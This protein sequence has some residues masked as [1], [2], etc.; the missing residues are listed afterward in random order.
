MAESHDENILCHV[1]APLVMLWAHA[2]KNQTLAKK[3]HI[4]SS[5]SVHNQKELWKCF[6]TNLRTSITLKFKKNTRK[7]QTG[8]SSPLPW[9]PLR[10]FNFVHFTWHQNKHLA[11]IFENSRLFTLYIKAKIKDFFHSEVCLYYTFQIWIHTIFSIIS[12]VDPQMQDK[13]ISNL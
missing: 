5:S 2:L 6:K 7:L 10:N 13:T 11:V 1:T 4:M 8:P 12:Q 9:L 3:E